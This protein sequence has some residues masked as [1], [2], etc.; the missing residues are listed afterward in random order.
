MCR[1]RSS[2]IKFTLV[3]GLIACG[4]ASA[5]Q[6]ELSELSSSGLLAEAGQSL[7]VDNYAGAIP[8]L[9]EY[10]NR[11]EGVDDDRVI[12]LM[13]SV[14]LKLGQIGAY[15]EDSSMAV[16]Y[17]KEYT[18]QL[19]CLQPREAWKL[20][21]LNL[22]ELSEF[23]ECVKA[24][25]Y[26]LTEPEPKELPGSSGPVDVDALSQDERGGLTA[27]QLKRI[28]RE[29]KKK[30]KTLRAE[31]AIESAPDREPAYSVEELVMLNMTLAEANMKMN[32]WAECIEPYQYVVANETDEERR[33]YAIL[34]LIT[35][36]IGLERYEE[37]KGS[38]LELYQ[39]NARYNIR[40]NMALM[41]AAAALFN[42]EEYDSALLLYRMVLPRD[43]LIVYQVEKM[44]GLRREAGL[45]D[46]EMVISTNDVGRVETVFGDKQAEFDVV[47]EGGFAQGLPPKPEELL[48]LE[49]SV[50]ILI[51]LPPYENDV[52]FRCGLIF[53]QSGRPWEAVEALNY[54]YEQDPDAEIGQRAFAE[55]MFVLVNPL[56]EFAQVEV[57]GREFLATYDEG[58]APRQVA[59][60][61]T[62]AYQ[63]QVLWTEVKSLLPIIERFADSSNSTVLRYECELYF[64]QAIADM[65]LL[66]YFEARVG[67][68]R[69]LIDYPDSHQQENARYWHAMAQQFLK[70]FQD[71]Y[72]EFVA[73]EEAYPTGEWLP[74]VVFNMGVSQFGLENYEEAKDILTRAIS[75]FPND[76]V[77][78][79]ALALRGDLYAADGLLDEA[80]AD[81]RNAIASAQTV[82]QDSY[83]V[84]QLVSMFDL[85]DR[86]EDT[87]ELLYTYLTRCGD[88]ADVAKAT[89]WIGKTKINQGL[90][91]EAIEVYKNTILDYGHDIAQEG[92]DLIITETIKVSR[93]LSEMERDVL[94]NELE[95]TRYDTDDITLELRLRVLI[96]QMRDEADELGQKL[97]W[98][99]DDLTLAPPPVLAVIC[100]ASLA[101][102]DFSRSDEILELFTSRYETSDFMRSALKLSAYGLYEK[103]ELDGALAMAGEAQALYG[104]EADLVWS[105]L[106]KG[107][108]RIEQQEWEAAEQ[109]FRAVLTVRE[110]RGAPYAESMFQ[111]GKIAE[112]SGKLSTAFGWYQRTYFQFRAHA[113]GYWAAEAYLASAEVLDA[114][115]LENDKRNTYR[116]MLFD[117]FVNSLPQAEVART[118][119]GDE[120]VVEIEIK[121]ELGESLALEE[122]IGASLK[123]EDE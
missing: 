17:L 4:M 111:L 39:T 47:E 87:V 68:E 77:Y 88:E 52:I 21:A 32:L 103:G 25:Q 102:K 63:K 22:F 66:N 110:W 101:N 6:V 116:A 54:V 71:S 85:E 92:V 115:G 79:D 69:V 100:D 37:A 28:E 107:M 13:Q 49:D 76:V 42:A 44:N 10:L 62:M 36:Y 43:E 90:I 8:Y 26:A 119:L 114:L 112:L 12:A 95:I 34:Q 117:R 97:I 86:Y 41:S 83:A 81:Y 98:E 84:F 7:S 33:G 20:L 106:L 94:L 70:N 30:K 96:A 120:E 93:R 99:L 2:K 91:S 121:M 75:K 89:Y 50:S 108:I 51:S 5:Q 82:R 65:V 18:E 113:K 109:A 31:Q 9:N 15:L 122:P 59:Y 67:F 78:S 58:L 29:E 48:R 16:S 74:S 123:G 72:D 64:M 46:V 104:T 3:V 1:S 53:V 61:M 105:Q 24:A 27:R 55:M 56:E 35:A 80:E 45:P 11:M 14:R 57:R 118:Y 23:P 40:V 38:I 19:P 60:A 73:Y